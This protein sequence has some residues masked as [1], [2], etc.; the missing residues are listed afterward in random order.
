MATDYN[1]YLSKPAAINTLIEAIAHTLSAH[2]QGLSEYELI[3]LLK[4]RG[5]LGFLDPPPAGPLDLFRAH[6]LL[7][8]ALYRL[9]GRLL[10]SQEADIHI[11]TLKI[12]QLP[13]RNA[14]TALST[15]DNLLE[16]YLDLSHLETTSSRDVSELISS[17]WVRLQNQDRRKEA[18]ME[19]GLED[20]VDNETITQ[21]Y[22]RMAMKHHPDRGGSKT[23]LQAL[24]SA[25]KVL[26]KKTNTGGG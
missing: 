3:Q 25:V 5:H 22:R 8:H 20:P 21:T 1:T 26:T 15:P 14:Q 4:A 24:N 17:F 7:F 10:Q 19:L 13:Y 16:Y 12:R 23:R 2:P 18:L 11:S 6:F 9:R